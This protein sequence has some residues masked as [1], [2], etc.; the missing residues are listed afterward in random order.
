MKQLTWSVEDNK[1]LKGCFNIFLLYIFI[2]FCVSLITDVKCFLLEFGC[3]RGWKHHIL[4]TKI[5]KGAWAA[6]S[7][8]LCV[9]QNLLVLTSGFWV[10]TWNSCF[11]QC[12]TLC[13]M[14]K[15]HKC[16]RPCCHER[17]AISAFVVA[18]SAVCNLHTGT[19]EEER[20]CQHFKRSFS[21]EQV[22]VS[23][24]YYT[25]AAHC[26]KLKVT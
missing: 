2:R 14:L 9:L 3:R 23:Q 16:R 26:E 18:V 6:L 19:R 15:R 22:Q 21:S 4:P 17:P 5:H 20:T 13:P 12:P 24:S 11:T 7:P 10:D 8:N 1:F 25:N